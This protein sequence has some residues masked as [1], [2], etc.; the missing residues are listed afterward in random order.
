MMGERHVDQEALFFGFSLERH[1]PVGHLLRAIDRFVDLSDLRAR[2]APF[3]SETGRSAANPD[4]SLI[5]SANSL[6]SHLNSLFARHRELREK[7]PGILAIPAR[8]APLF[9]LRTAEIPCYFPAEQGIQRKSNRA[10][11]G[12]NS[13]LMLCSANVGN[14]ALKS[15]DWRHFAPIRSGKGS[16]RESPRGTHHAKP[17]KLHDPIGL[18]GKTVLFKD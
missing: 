4:R 14:C 5:G 13:S 17:R 3:Y 6:F 12:S 15:R 18:L 10:P 2:L 8:P 9:G 11:A 7:T 16:P 1:V